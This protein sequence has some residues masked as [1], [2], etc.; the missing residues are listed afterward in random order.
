MHTRTHTS[1]NFCYV[2][3]MEP[4]GLKKPFRF[5]EMQNLGNNGGENHSPERRK[6]RKA[7]AKKRSN[8][9]TSG[10][11]PPCAEVTAQIEANYSSVGQ[12]S[13]N[14]TVTDTIRCRYV[15]RVELGTLLAKLFPSLPFPSSCFANYSSHFTSPQGRRPA[16]PVHE[17]K[18]QR[19]NEAGRAGLR[20]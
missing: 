17:A 14:E 20:A 4:V 12:S 2:R 16:F 8:Q 6:K 5:S 10:I 9:G 19:N 3:T 18:T 11:V 7:I 13:E 15:V 1:E